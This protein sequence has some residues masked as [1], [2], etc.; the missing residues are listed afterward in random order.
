MFLAQKDEDHQSW[1]GPVA[2]CVNEDRVRAW[3]GKVIARIEAG[4]SVPCLSKPFTASTLI[5][6]STPLTVA[7]GPKSLKRFE[8][9]KHSDERHTISNLNFFV[10]VTTLRCASSAIQT[11]TIEGS[12]KMFKLILKVVFGRIEVSNASRINSGYSDGKHDGSNS[13]QWKRT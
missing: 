4:G 1:S 13:G 10:V 11:Q 3:W 8:A 2:P 6:L 12:S 5:G 9:I 7:T